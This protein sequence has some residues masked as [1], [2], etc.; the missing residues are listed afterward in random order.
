MQNPLDTM[1]IRRG[2]PNNTFGMVRNNNTKPHQ[3]WDL[4]ALPGTPV[5]AIAT[6]RAEFV[7]NKGAYG[8][9]ICQ[10][11]EHRGQP[12]YAFYAHL[13]HAL[14]KNGDKITEGQL[15]GY[16]GQTGNASGQCEADAHLHFEIRLVPRPGLGL[17]GRIDPGEIL[18]YEIYSSQP[19]P[20]G[21]ATP[22]AHL[23]RQLL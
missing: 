19:A 18:G 7:E 10:T 17:A 23:P 5:Y 2:I 14:V 12:L 3:G 22:A 11:F 16:S 1:R 20:A 6:G 13:E 8:V 15:I 4:A 9:Q 21:S